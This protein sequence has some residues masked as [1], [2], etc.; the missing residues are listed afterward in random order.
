MPIFQNYL[1][2]LLPIYGNEA[3]LSTFLWQRPVPQASASDVSCQYH[4]NHAA[5]YPSRRCSP[6]ST[7]MGKPTLHHLH[8]NSCDQL[9]TPTNHNYR[10]QTFLKQ[11]RIRRKLFREDSLTIKLWHINVR[12]RAWVSFENWTPR[13]RRKEAETWSTR[14]NS[15]KDQEVCWKAIYPFSQRS[16]QNGEESFD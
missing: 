6:S 11:E 15:P 8:W 7:L 14:I 13:W 4:S 2:S 1:N 9:L 3:I 10:I 12:C 16:P 5:Y